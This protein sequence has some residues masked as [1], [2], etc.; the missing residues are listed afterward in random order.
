[1]DPTQ[2]VAVMT[3]LS[4]AGWTGKE[5]VRLTKERNTERA[6][7]IAAEKALK[8]A[9]AAASAAVKAAAAEAKIAMDAAERSEDVWREKYLAETTA[10][11]ETTASISSLQ[12][13]LRAL[14][15]TVERQTK[16]IGRQ[17]DE[18]KELREQIGQMESGHA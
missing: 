1:M 16:Q 4:T 11:A 2:I 14:R 3:G 18:I 7:R 12:G 8:A 5:I 17:A 13:E 6:G 10:H 15:E 9:E